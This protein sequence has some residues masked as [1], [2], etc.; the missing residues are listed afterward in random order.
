MLDT[1]TPAQLSDSI[2]SGKLD[3]PQGSNVLRVEPVCDEPIMIDVKAVVYWPDGLIETGAARLDMGYKTSPFAQLA[4]SR[5][6]DGA[7]VQCE[8]TPIGGKAKVGVRMVCGERGKLPAVREKTT[9]V[10]K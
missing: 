3:A 5:P 4:F 7:K 8:A 1:T 9:K 6:L 2:R 10:Q